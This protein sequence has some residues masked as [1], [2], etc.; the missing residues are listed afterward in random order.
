MDNLL[1][2]HRKRG[3]KDVLQSLQWKSFSDTTRADRDEVLRLLGSGDYV[4]TIAF[5]P[6]NMAKGVDKDERF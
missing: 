1:F 6:A 4:Q 2:F 5:V 3:N